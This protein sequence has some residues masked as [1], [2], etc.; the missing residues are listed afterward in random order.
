MKKA[1]LFVL[2]IFFVANVFAQTPSPKPFELVEYGINIEPD[3]RLI[4]VM[5]A[6]EAAGFDANPGKEPSLFRKQLRSD[7]KTVDED[8][9]KRMKVFFD[10]NNKTYNR[11]T[12]AEQAAPYIS[13]AYSLT[14]VP[15]LADPPRSTDLPSELLEV[16][17]F[18]P[19]VREFYRRSGIDLKMTEY[20]RSYQAV[21]D[22]FKPSAKTMASDI[23]GYLHTKPQLVYL[24][25]VTTQTKN[26]GQ[27]LSKTEFRERE[28]RF[29][30][31][32]DLLSVSSTINFRNTG[33]D[34]YAIVPPNTDLTSSE[35]RRAYLQ[36]VLDPLV[37]RNG[38]DISPHR[39]GIRELLLEREKAGVEVSRDV[40]L[41]IT[42]SLV[43]AVDAKEE[44]FF[45]IQRGTIQARQKI[46]QTKDIEG[47]KAVSAEL[48]RL[49]AEW[50]DETALRLSE[51]YEKGAVLAFY[52]AEQLKGIEDSGFDIASSFRDML[53]SL[54]LSR[55]KN[56]LGESAEARK[57][58]LQARE[59]RKKKAQEQ[60][61]ANQASAVKETE[62]IKK[63]SLIEEMIRLKQY[64]KSDAELLEMD[65]Q[66]PNN[67]RIFYARGRV[68][69]LS[70]EDAIDEE[71]RDERLGR[72]A[73]FYRNAILSANAETPKA[74]IS[75]AHVALGRILEFNEQ[76]QSALREYEAAIKIGNI[77]DGAYQEALIAR[78]RLTKKP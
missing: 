5:A 75:L 72:A 15:E 30:I 10:R 31:V 64:E 7:F 47:K 45:K 14:P 25:K 24:D 33:D 26:K 32:P 78:E 46:D 77:K 57:R 44:E 19:L 70:A 22:E 3:K 48:N 35:V 54:D 76:A 2:L 28:R 36:F 74:L 66:Y 6:L 4:V 56:R 18:A 43:A 27:T 61:L 67:S 69:S 62:F 37:L 20:Y 51:S 58:A 21:G 8:L 12:P 17:D 13:L 68:A 60:I 34:Y 59:I 50:A 65:K 42:R 53:L 23:L 16:L 39:E 52:F 49:K 55:E 1:F 73:A 63:L 29:F 38:K 9:K 40:F 71:V 41:A 11:L